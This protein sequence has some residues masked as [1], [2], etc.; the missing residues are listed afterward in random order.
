VHRKCNRTQ[1][2]LFC[3]EVVMHLLQN[4]NLPFV[5]EKG[6]PKP[7]PIHPGMYLRSDVLPKHP[8]V[9]KNLRDPATLHGIRD[10]TGAL[11]YAVAVLS[12]LDGFFCLSDKARVQN[13]TA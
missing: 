2:R 9:F 11:A 5:R 7:L 10:M 12:I 8:V 4:L 6:L 1:S 3:A 13:F